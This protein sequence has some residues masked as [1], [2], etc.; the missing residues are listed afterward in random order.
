MSSLQFSLFSPALALWLQLLIGCCSL[1]SPLS[2]LSFSPS[3]PAYALASSHTWPDIPPLSSHRLHLALL[4][5]SSSGSSCS[6]LSSSCCSLS[7]SHT[8]TLSFSLVWI[9][10]SSIYTIESLLVGRSAGIIS[11]ISCLNASLLDIPRGFL[12]AFVRHGKLGKR[13]EQ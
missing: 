8:H 4:Q 7:L 6:L 3:H 12:V 1:A 9:E 5:P 10:Y 13:Q 11:L 2:L